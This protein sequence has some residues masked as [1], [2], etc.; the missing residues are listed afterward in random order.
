MGTKRE[1]E[2]QRG[3]NEVTFLQELVAQVTEAE[4]RL[5]TL[6]VLSWNIQIYIMLVCNVVTTSKR[7][8][9]CSGELA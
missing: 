9:F 4:R 3:V 7:L 1:R 5:G 2:V 8:Q 6:T